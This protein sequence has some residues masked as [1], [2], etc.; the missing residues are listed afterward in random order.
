MDTYR[1]LKFFTGLKDL[2]R[3]EIKL[4]ITLI[5]D[6]RSARQVFSASE[7]LCS[8][9]GKLKVKQSTNNITQVFLLLFYMN[10]YGERDL[11]CRITNHGFFTRTLSQV[12][13]QYLSRRWLPG[14][15]I[16]PTFIT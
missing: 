14:I 16:T 6:D 10:E 1:L 2:K 15:L 11:T 3:V 7:E 12:T 9:I 5:L 13:I 4:V 8:F